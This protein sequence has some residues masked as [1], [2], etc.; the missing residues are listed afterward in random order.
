MSP[1]D[2]VSLKT[3]Y[4]L[5]HSHLSVSL[6]AQQGSELTPTEDPGTG[7]IHK[8]TTDLHPAGR[9]QG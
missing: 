2:R 3:G 9:C 7:L 4:L 8:Q 1:I 5:L 6:S